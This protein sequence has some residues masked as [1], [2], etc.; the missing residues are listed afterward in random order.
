VDDVERAT[1]LFRERERASDG[2][3]LGL[4]GTARRVIAPPAPACGRRVRGEPGGQLRA[5]GVDCDRQA[6]LRRA[7]H[8][9]SQRLV[10]G[11]REV[12]DSARAHE[13][14]EA[15]HAQLR[16]LWQVTDVARHEASPEGE[17]HTRRA[18]GCR[19]LEPERRRVH[20]RRTRVER[21]VDDAGRPSCGGRLAACGEALPVGSA[22][23]VEVHVH[24]HAAGEDMQTVRLDLLA[25]RSTQTRFDR[26]DRAVDDADVA[27]EH[28]LAD[29]GSTPN[30]DVELHTRL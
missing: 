13:R 3:E 16:E 14:L 20:R 21:H 1:R 17:I 25:G 10:V 12:A 6:E 22:R 29:D 5:L 27:C 9:L 8:A 7:S 28:L 30:Q 24:V 2:L 18:L 11:G 19:Q 4:D 26:D 15:D 23:V